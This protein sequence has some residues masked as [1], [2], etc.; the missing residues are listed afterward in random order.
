MNF[1]FVMTIFPA[2]IALKR[3]WALMVRPFWAKVKDKT[4][5]V[6]SLD[7][8]SM[9]VSYVWVDGMHVSYV[10]VKNTKNQMDTTDY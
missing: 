6:T 1:V 9:H 7:P 5:E 8:L 2:A 3:Q 4:S 10:W